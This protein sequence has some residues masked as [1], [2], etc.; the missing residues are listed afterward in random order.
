MIKLLH[1]KNTYK[2][3]EELKNIIEGFKEDHKKTEVDSFGGK[4]VNF[5]TL[6]NNLRQGSLFQK[7][8]LIILKNISSKKKILEELEGSLSFFTDSEDLLVFVEEKKLKKSKKLYKLADKKG[9]VE[10]FER[11]EGKELRN[12]IK[13]KVKNKKAKINE[14]SI[15]LLISYCGNDLWRL[16]NEIN[17]LV[18]YKSEGKIKKE[19]VETLVNPDIEPG[20]F[21][22][23]DALAKKDKKKALRSLEFHFQ[24]GDSPFYLLKMITFQFRNLLVASHLKNHNKKLKDFYNLDICSNYPAKKAW[25][26]V[27]E[28]SFSKLKSIYYNIFKVDRAIKTGQID[29]EEGLRLLIAKI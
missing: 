2:I 21:K 11:I 5:K 19:D 29:P 26:K 28:F 8:K 14:N 24:Q 27:S 6:K 4:E 20:I 12:W 1:G 7:R 18:C 13:K 23:I 16:E 3:K 22:T 10:E 9:E 15:D 25:K 17:K